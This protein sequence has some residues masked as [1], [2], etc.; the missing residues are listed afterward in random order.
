MCLDRGI[1]V[2]CGGVFNS[3]VLASGGTYDY[4]PAAPAVLE[5]TQRLREVCARHGVP[6]K[7]AAIQFPLGHRAV[8]CVVVGA[9]SGGEVAE[10]DA[11][12]RFEIPAPFW[13]DV[14]RE[15]L[16][17]EDVPVPEG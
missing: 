12:F 1:A 11:M 16:L 15:G 17:P 8:T 9:R 4:A 3:G 2:I 6:L 13:E 14:R 7:A 10:N 5:R